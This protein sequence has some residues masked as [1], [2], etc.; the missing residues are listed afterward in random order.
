MTLHMVVL[1]WFISI[2]SKYSHMLMVAEDIE[3][4]HRMW[5]TVG[6][7]GNPCRGP[8]FTC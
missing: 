8:F 3:Y 4:M 1:V 6:Q 5:V 7:A 2:L